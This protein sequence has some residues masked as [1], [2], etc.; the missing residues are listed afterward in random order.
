MLE[1]NGISKEYKNGVKALQNINLTIGKGMFG[2]LG[3]NG[4]GKSSLMRTLATLQ[5]PDS[6]SI[7]FDGIDVLQQPDE[8]KK[9]LGYLPQE[10]GVYPRVSAYELLNYLAVMKGISNKSARKEQVLS[11]L[12]QTNLYDQRNNDVATFSGGMKRRFGIAQAL[13]AEPKLIMVDEPTAGLDPQ[14]RNRFY[15]LL[16]DL[17]EN[18]VLILSTHI[19]EDIQELCTDMAIINKGQVLRQGSPRELM[20]EIAGNVWVKQSGSLN[21]EQLQRDHKVLSTKNAGA[22]RVVY[23]HSQHQPENGFELIDPTLEDVY[24]NALMQSNSG[25]LCTSS[26]VIAGE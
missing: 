26:N 11:L 5:L 20:A 24:F 9:V 16:C 2:L 8:L 10:F 3:P 14:E 7:T 18:I 19:I 15:N 13:L 25:G 12:E 21:V 6:G 22:N 4:A 17:G 23:I 1:I